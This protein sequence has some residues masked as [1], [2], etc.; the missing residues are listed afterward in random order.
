MCKVFDLFLRNEESERSPA[1]ICN[2]R[3]SLSDSHLR[4][5]RF[6]KFLKLKNARFFRPLLGVSVL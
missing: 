6:L 3:L 1:K 5:F 4:L 2:R